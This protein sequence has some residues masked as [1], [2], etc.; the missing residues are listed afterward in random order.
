MKFSIIMLMAAVL[1]IGLVGGDELTG[2][3][4]IKRVNDLL[5]PYSSYSKAK[6]TIV[7]SS[8][9]SRTFVFESWSKNHGE[10]NLIR[11]IEPR[12]SRGQATLMLNHADDI[13]MYFPRTKRVRKLAIHAK[14][15]KM[16]GSDFSYED[17]GSGD[18]FI[19]DFVAKRLGD[20]KAEGQMCYKLELIRKSNSDVS[21]SKIILWVRKVDF[22][23]LIIDYYK[24]D[25]PDI[26]EK[27]LVMSNI[28][29]IQNVPT[30]MK[31]IMYN[32]LDNT[33]TEMEF[34]DV[35]YNLEL[36]DNIFTERGLRR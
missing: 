1:S 30:A 14:K 5:N 16:E 28:K 10:K 22:C 3:Q 35:K 18:I 4:I 25:N 2:D 32:M 8:G 23:P 27:R 6:L 12:R 21:Y 19:K 13:W 29:L 11:Y 26:V 15:Q 7:T 24:Q 31:M 34:L 36:E 20:E 17:M 33:K 9:K